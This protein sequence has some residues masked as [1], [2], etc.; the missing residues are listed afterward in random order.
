MRGGS[1]EV[2]RQHDARPS[3]KASST[4]GDVDGA[5]FCPIGRERSSGVCVHT[6]TIHTSVAAKAIMVWQECK[7]LKAQLAMSQ[8]AGNEAAEEVF[9]KSAHTYSLQSVCE[10]SETEPTVCWHQPAR[11]WRRSAFASS[12]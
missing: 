7:A 9:V 2:V 6:H 1:S 8:A 4:A 3:W 5:G 11:R 12:A 10:P